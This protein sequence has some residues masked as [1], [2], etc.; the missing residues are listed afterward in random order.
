MS[1]EKDVSVSA[2]VAKITREADQFAASGNYL[3]A[4]QKA[5]SAPFG[6]DDKNGGTICVNSILGS[7]KEAEISKFVDALSEEE[8]INAMKYIYKAMA[9]DKLT[10]GLTLLKWH[11]TIFDKDGVGV[12]MRVLIDRKLAL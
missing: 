2:E 10:N 4:L 9:L 11:S 5:I 12:I 6:K 3:K 1:E 7:V 8:R